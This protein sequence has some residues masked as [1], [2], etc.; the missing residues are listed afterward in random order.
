MQMLTVVQRE[1]APVPM[2]AEQPFER[3]LRSVADG[4]KVQPPVY[5]RRQW[6]TGRGDKIGYYFIITKADERDLIVVGESERVKQFI[7]LQR[8]KV[9]AA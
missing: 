9:I 8:L 7:E 5:F 4:W 6:Y 3:L 1:S 2:D